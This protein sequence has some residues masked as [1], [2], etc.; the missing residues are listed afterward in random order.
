MD[1]TIST[2]ER[3]G[4]KNNNIGKEVESSRATQG[5]LLGKQSEN[6]TLVEFFP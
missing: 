1:N 6:T 4:T 2:Y 3:T 5:D